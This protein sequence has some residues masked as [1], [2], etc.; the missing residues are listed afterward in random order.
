MPTRGSETTQ[1]LFRYAVITVA[2]HSKD[3]RML[4]EVTKSVN[5]LSVND[6]ATDPF[7]LVPVCIDHL[8]APRYARADDK[9][10][11][12]VRDIADWKLVRRLFVQGQFQQTGR[13]G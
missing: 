8:A 1:A 4:T 9:G 6:A 2:G 13:S 5:R 7:L 11:K 10:E 3:A 12:R